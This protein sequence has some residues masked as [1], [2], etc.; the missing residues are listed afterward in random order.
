MELPRLFHFFMVFCCLE[1]CL[2]RLRLGLVLLI[3][4]LCLFLVLFLDCFDWKF[5]AIFYFIDCLEKNWLY[6]LGRPFLP[7]FDFLN[8][9]K[10]KN[11]LIFHLLSFYLNFF[12]LDF[13]FFKLNFC[14]FIAL[15][16]YS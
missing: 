3:H 7:N 12:N 2:C 15:I 5:I 9:M 13:V 14:V 1:I 6:A 11:Q 8:F 4:F 10:F 16:Y